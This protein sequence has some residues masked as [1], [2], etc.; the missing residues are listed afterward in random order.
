MDTGDLHRREV[1]YHIAVHMEVGAV[2][3]EVLLRMVVD[4]QAVHTEVGHTLAAEDIVH[5]AGPDAGHDVGHGV[6]R[7]VGHGAGRDGVRDVV[8]D[9]TLE[10]K[11]HY[12]PARKV[13]HHR[14]IQ[15]PVRTADCS[16]ATTVDRSPAR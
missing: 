12:T 3:T 11:V 7:G 13:A 4:T 9:R 8:V 16:P 5:G 2:R 14:D 15:I 6:G 1:V 10:M